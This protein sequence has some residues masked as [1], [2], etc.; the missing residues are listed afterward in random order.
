MI[1]RDEA[2][3][4][5]DRQT[6]DNNGQF[7]F[8]DDL[9][10]NTRYNIDVVLTDPLFLPY[11]PSPLSL[12]PSGGTT[13]PSDE[14]ALLISGNTVLRRPVYT[15]DFGVARLDADLPMVERFLIGDR[16]FSDTNANGIQDTGQLKL[17][18]I[19]YSCVEKMLIFVF[20]NQSNR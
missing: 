11:Q 9:V 7:L 8:D 12:L 2:G 15:R 1:L 18:F 6:T 19:I 3:V 14:R 17:L 16:L 13:S 4:E 20:F 5:V 10:A